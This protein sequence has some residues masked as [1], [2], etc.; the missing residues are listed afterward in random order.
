MRGKVTVRKMI[1]RLTKNPHTQFNKT[2]LYFLKKELTY[3]K[4]KII[5]QHEQSNEQ[6]ARA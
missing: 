1:T 4:N 5:Q 6:S 3:F 2:Q